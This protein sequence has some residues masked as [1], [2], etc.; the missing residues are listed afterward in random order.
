MRKLLIILSFC[1]GSLATVMAQVPEGTPFLFE[2]DIK[3][4]VVIDSVLR[5]IS[6][7]VEALEDFIIESEKVGYNAG[8]VYANNQ[9]GIYYR[10]K[11]DYPKSE[12]YHKTALAIAESNNLTDF[13]IMALNMLGVV[14]RR[15][16][17]V[18]V[19]LDYHKQALELAEK[20]GSRGETNLRSTAVSRN[21][22][23]NLYLTL[24]QED[25][26]LN[27]FLESIKI[28]E[29]IGNNLGLAINYQNIGGLYEQKGDFKSAME[30]YEKSLSYNEK[31]NSDLGRV[32]CYNS[33]AQLYLKQG[34]AQEA[35]KLLEPTIPKAEAIEDDYYIVMAEQNYGWA[36]LELGQL[37]KAENYLTKALATAK[38]LGQQYFVAESYKH[39]SVLAEQKGRYKE[40]L[41]YNKLYHENEE[42]YLNEKNQQYV[43]DLILKYDSDKKKSQIEIL[44]KENELVNVKLADNRRFL[45]ILIFCTILL[46]SIFYILYRQ[47][48]LNRE[49]QFLELEQKM[50]R[51]QMNPHFIF[52]SLNS[53]KLY[54]I[55]NNKDKAVYYLN[56]FSK[57]IR[58][59]LSNSKEKDITL[60]DEL[61]TMDLYMNIENIRFSNKIHFNIEVEEG[62]ETKQVRIPSL[63]L[64][65]FLENAIWHGLSSKEGD[66]ILTLSVAQS[67]TNQLTI[68]IEDNGIGREKSR[69][70]KAKKTLKNKSIGIDLTEERLRN[71]YEEV[72]GEHKLEIIDLYDDQNEACGTR[73]NLVIPYY[74][75]FK[76]KPKLQLS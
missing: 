41:D 8:L 39:L 5:P 26:A 2:E 38:N 13:R 73:V 68:A 25:L 17:Q 16:E 40:A 12:N 11:A 44:E 50:M 37:N 71:Y 48:N 75:E 15:K 46:A 33:I 3:E 22:I 19:A 7:K 57:L 28:E 4:Y 53:I 63:I 66:K 65:P 27:E 35:L 31:I 55:S 51:S 52:N 72:K 36:L 32:I 56:K 67:A 9:L 43:A 74:A 59:I 49:K 60:E 45:I 14:A 10:N 30:S 29:K 24:R 54:I 1:F 42:Q 70:I 58:T 18:R 64:Q 61:Q 21:S 47:N 6:Y 62:I 69:E 76:K 34:K 23:G 20:Q